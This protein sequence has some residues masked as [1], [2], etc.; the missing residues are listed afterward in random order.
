MSCSLA[1]FSQKLVQLVFQPEELLN[2][3]CT[4]TRG[5]QALD[6]VQLGVVKSYVFKLH[7]FATS[8]EDAQW[9]KCITCIDKFLRRKKRGTR[10]D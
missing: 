3:N 8:L 7:P 5:K 2:R 6:Q 4:G 10:V 1:N 9:R